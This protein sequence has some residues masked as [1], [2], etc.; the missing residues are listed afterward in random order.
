MEGGKEEVEVKNSLERN[1]MW[2]EETRIH[3]NLWIS[4]FRIDRFSL[5][6]KA[7]AS[8]YTSV[9]PNS[10]IHS[11]VATGLDSFKCNSETS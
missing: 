9:A 8:S 2:R 3:E 11:T 4:E 7:T 5:A 1:G 10:N 6:G